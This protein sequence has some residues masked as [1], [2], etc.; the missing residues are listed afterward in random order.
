M[1]DGRPAPQPTSHCNIPANAD[2]E[3]MDKKIRL[4]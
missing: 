1:P 4:S 3:I 2:V